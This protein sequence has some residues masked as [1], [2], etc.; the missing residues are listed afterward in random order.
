MPK[1]V[2]HDQY[3]KELL[4]KSFSLLAQNGYAN[5]TMRQIATELGVSTGTLYH[6]FPNKE[7]LFLQLV[8]EQTQNDIL[9]FRSATPISG[10]LFEKITKIMAFVAQNEDYFGKQILIWI[11]FYRT[12][13]PQEFSNNEILKQLNER[14]KEV[15]KDYLNI[16]DQAIVDVI[17]SWLHGIL[18]LR[19]F[20]RETVS[21]Q[22]QSIVLSNMINAY[23]ETQKQE[24][25]SP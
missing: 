2:N 17:F 25:K 18:L 22:E 6:Y 9:N 15:I 1:I 5:I 13:E 4:S 24:K 8:L 20:E 21:F 3:R 11:D 12:K 16:E 10:T 23:L 14:V 19:V 7:A